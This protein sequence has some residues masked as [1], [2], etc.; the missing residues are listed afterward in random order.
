[1]MVSSSRWGTTGKCPRSCNTP[2][3]R[4]AVA[5]WRGHARTSLFAY[6]LELGFARTALDESFR[7]PAE[8]AAF[9]HRHVYA[10]DGIAFHSQN[11]QRLPA[12]EVADGWLPHAL[13]PEHPIILIEHND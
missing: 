12:V 6:L 11:R 7:L 5:T 10:H 8:V 4:P 3:I 9:L 13:A 2:G 1:M